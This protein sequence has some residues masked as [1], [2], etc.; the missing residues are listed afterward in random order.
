MVLYIFAKLLFFYTTENRG[1][2]TTKR[3][4]CN[5]MFIYV[6]TRRPLTEAHL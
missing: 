3:S 2:K 6:Q 1:G 5:V 4:D